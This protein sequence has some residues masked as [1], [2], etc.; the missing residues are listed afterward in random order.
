M[1]LTDGL[2][3]S[4]WL[5]M[6]GILRFLLATDQTLSALAEARGQSLDELCEALAAALGEEHRETVERLR[7]AECEGEAIWGSPEEV[8]AE[9]HYWRRELAVA[10]VAAGSLPLPLRDGFQRAAAQPGSPAVDSAR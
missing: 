6:G 10:A 2:D 4:G 3:P 5:R 9:R 1:G 7:V 8:A